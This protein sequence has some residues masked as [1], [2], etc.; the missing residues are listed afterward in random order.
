MTIEEISSLN[1]IY[2]SDFQSFALSLTRDVDRA[3]DLL[4]EVSYQVFKNRDS[5]QH[6]TNF[7]AWVKRIIR[8][9]FISDYRRKKRRER[10]IA[11]NQVPDGWLLEASV[12]NTAERILEQ[13]DAYALISQLPKIH[14]RAF[15]L[16]FQGMSYREIA[17]RI[18]VPTGTVKSRI[19]AA[20]T[21]LKKKLRQRDIRA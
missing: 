3:Q 16:H 12:P 10:I 6:G 18:Q 19:F 7:K 20:R 14:R 11:K 17:L 13:E 9:T 2:Y 21:L 4:Q 5:F 15:L 1:R 8:N